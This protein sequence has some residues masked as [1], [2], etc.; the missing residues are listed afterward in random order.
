MNSTTLDV[1]SAVSAFWWYLSGLSFVGGKVQLLIGNNNNDQG[2]MFVSNCAFQE[3]A[4]AAI[5]MLPPA[6]AL[7]GWANGTH[8]NGLPIFPAPPG[9][10]R[11]RGGY[12]TQ[13]SVKDSKF[14]ECNQVQF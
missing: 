13:L 5:H 1:F 7:V 3:S 11:W 2:Q 12:S 10:T 8:P 9:Q 14:I 6:G 4:G